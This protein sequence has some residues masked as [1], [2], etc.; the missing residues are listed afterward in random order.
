MGRL[1]RIGRK[2]FR[3]TRDDRTRPDSILRRPP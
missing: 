2:P 1:L 3:S